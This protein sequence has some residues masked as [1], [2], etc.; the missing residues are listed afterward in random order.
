MSLSSSCQK[1]IIKAITSQ[2]IKV[3]VPGVLP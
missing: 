2:V 1:E 3:I